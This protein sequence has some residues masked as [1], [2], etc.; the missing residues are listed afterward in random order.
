MEFGY[1]AFVVTGV[2]GYLNWLKTIITMAR[3]REAESEKLAPDA[4]V[5]CRFLV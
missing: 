5:K 3:Q 1:R 2:R 4:I